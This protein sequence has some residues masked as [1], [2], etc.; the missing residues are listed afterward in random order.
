MRD[1]LM[2]ALGVVRGVPK[3]A[4]PGYPIGGATIDSVIFEIEWAI[5][6]GG[7]RRRDP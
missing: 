4:P 6:L 7:E 3:I 1:A 5:R 2:A